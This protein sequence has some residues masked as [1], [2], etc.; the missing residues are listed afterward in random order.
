VIAFSHLDR[1]LHVTAVILSGLAPK[2]HFTSVYRFLREGVWDLE[3]VRRRVWQLCQEHAVTAGPRIF[4]A[5]DADVEKGSAISMVPSSSTMSH[6]A[7]TPC[8]WI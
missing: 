8:K 1:R 7:R 3:T 6:L 5:V 4:F 2:R